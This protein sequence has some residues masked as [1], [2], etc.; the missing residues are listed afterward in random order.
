MMRGLAVHSALFAAATTGLLAQPAGQPAP[1]S[2]EDLRARQAK[3]SLQV[4]RV[5]DE[6]PSFTAQIVSYRSGTLT[7]HALVATPKSPP[8]AR[9]FPVLIAN[10]GTHPDPPRYGISESGVDAR[11]GDYYRPVPDLYASRGFIVVM[12][13]YRG[14]NTSEGVEFARGFLASAYFTEDVLALVDGL[15]GLRHA[16]LE[17]VF[18]WGHSLGG[19]VTLRALLATDRVRGASLWSTV[20]GDIWE[21]AYYYSRYKD[22]ETVDGSDVTKTAFDRLRHDIAALGTPYDWQ[23][24]EPLRYLHLLRTPLILHHAIADA[25]AKYEWAE[26]LAAQ[27]HLA[28]LE[29]FS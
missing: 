2:I 29:R 24:R 17:N 21:Q 3:T 15:S 6:G 16:D 26:R 27:L 14:H 10:H 23:A 1:R 22:R 18:M 13:D 11:P 5:L 25:G 12:P 9:G 28:G 7:V 19:E 20:G 8:P 4:V